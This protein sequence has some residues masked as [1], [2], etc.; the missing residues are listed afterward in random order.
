A[1]TARERT[2]TAAS[3]LAARLRQL[4]AAE[5]TAVMGDLVRTHAAAVLGHPGPEAVAPDRTFRDLGFD[6]LTAIELPNRLALATGLRMPATTVYD[7]PTAQAL[8]EHLVAEILGEQDTE[9][10][11]DRVSAVGLSDDPVVI[12]GMAC[13]LPG[14]VRSPE[15][16][17]RMLSE[18]RDGIEAFPE[19]RGWDLATL[20]T[21]GADGRG[22]S[23]TL[24]GG[25][26]AGAAE[27]DAGF[28][29]ISPREALAMD[30]Q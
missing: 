24:R 25:F 19:D 22:R 23:A 9:S 5:R 7:F 12:V 21:G 1:A 30:P 15:D 2:E 27:F 26:V 17:W 14:G 16:L 6:S 13:R 10:G 28:F 29:G 18:G 3:G 4:P 8:A 20:E 11:A